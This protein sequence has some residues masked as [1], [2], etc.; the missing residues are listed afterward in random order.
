[1]LSKDVSQ[2]LTMYCKGFQT[3][4]K[5]WHSSPDHVAQFEISAAAKPETIRRGYPLCPGCRKLFDEES[6]LTAARNRNLRGIRKQLIVNLREREVPTISP[7]RKTAVE[8]SIENLAEKAQKD[9]G[10]TEDEFDLYVDSILK[11]MPN[12]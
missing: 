2:M 12:L 9:F 8:K 6:K 7:E 4:D 5:A 11:S 10:W 3:S 1:M